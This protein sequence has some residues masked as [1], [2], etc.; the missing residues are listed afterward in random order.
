MKK[1]LVLLMLCTTGVYALSYNSSV[2]TN[3]LDTHMQD[4]EKER[5]GVD[6]L[7]PKERNALQEWINRNHYTKAKSKKG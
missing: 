5:T 6:K 2:S 3:S 7:T 1:F 4:H